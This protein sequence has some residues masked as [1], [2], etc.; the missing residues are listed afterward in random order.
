M[1]SRGACRAAGRARTALVSLLIGRKRVSVQARSA[2]TGGLGAVPCAA[3]I[4]GA[5]NIEKEILGLKSTPGPTYPRAAGGD[6]GIDGGQPMCG[7]LAQS[8]SISDL[9][10][11][12]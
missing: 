10:R 7:D 5:C 8:H 11:P 9:I 3:V 1:T 12:T 4:T 2:R 6:G